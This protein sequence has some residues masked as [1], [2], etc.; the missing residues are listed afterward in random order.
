MTLSESLKSLNF[1]SALIIDDA[2]DEVPVAS[3]LSLEKE[4]WSVFFDDLGD[5]TEQI[6]RVFPEYQG[7][8]A[9]ELRDSD[10]FVA[11]L[12]GL[13]SEL[14]A[15]LWNPLF[16]KYE[17][18]RA[19]D[20]DVLTAL[21]SRLETAGLVVETAGR[22][23][24][25]GTKEYSVI[26]ADLFLGA[27]QQ[28]FDIERS[29]GRVRDL[30]RGRESR[31]PAVVLMSRSPLLQDKKAL[32]RDDARL[33]GALF[34][35]YGK[36]DLLKEAAVETVL[37]RLATHY[38]DA[39]RIAAFLKAC[40][41]GL[42][43]A[44]ADFMKVIRR[45]DLSDYSK[46]RDLLLEAEGQPLGSYMMDVFDRVLQYEVE[47]HGET[48][49]RAQALDKIDPLKYPTP[50]LAGAPD[51]Q[52]LVARMLCQHPE[53]LRLAANTAGMPVSFGDILVRAPKAATASGDKE[54]DE[55]P[56]AFIV[57]TPACD[58]VRKAGSA[59][60]RVLLLG[61][62]VKPLDG[63]TWTYRSK[64]AVTPIVELPAWGRVS[65]EW[66]LDEQRLV[67]H[68]ELNELLAPDGPYS[69]RVRLRESYALELQQRML[70]EMGRVGVLSKMPFTFPVEVEVYT[71]DS[72]GMLMA[73]DLPDTTASGGVYVVGRDA[74]GK[75]F[76]RVVLIE[77]AVDEIVE[78]VPKIDE[79]LV[80]ARC[81][82]TLNRLKASTSFATSLQQGIRAP[83]TSTYGKLQSLKITEVGDQKSD[84]IVGLIGWNIDVAAKLTIGNDL[85]H[86]GFVVV[87][88]HPT[89]V[90]VVA[91]T[92]DDDAG[93]T[94]EVETAAS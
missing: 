7:M 82:E 31:P 90:D 86:C 6:E 79:T 78:A 22:T 92:A 8:K 44:A 91:V 51:L 42:A 65:I 93:A 68:G 4:S 94:P 27:S 85:K 36:N 9:E 53:R 16:Q 61:G 40:E 30:V 18:D 39:V 38:E 45:L 26:F 14:P 80:H 34:R 32:F 41:D 54:A 48:I 72:S 64:E 21:R 66:G 52:D 11:A 77:G 89:E 35:V 56:S 46:I 88:R 50:S 59:N 15:P 81:R 33:I 28:D 25:D 49:A 5:Q 23:G 24:H 69:I 73:I 60:R 71:T 37:R 62:T 58:L 70:A 75:D 12:Y 76:G 43:T 1:T 63:R 83:A 19:S 55:D 2:F 3:D 17:L 13:K 10:R 57:L 20:L 87:L 29:V 47:G 74:D 67:T 84:A